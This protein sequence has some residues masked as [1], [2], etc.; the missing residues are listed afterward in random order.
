M[1]MGW[2]SPTVIDTAHVDARIV[3]TYLRLPGAGS[4]SSDAGSLI[5]TAES[6][7]PP[8]GALW[9]AIIM[10]GI[11]VRLQGLASERFLLKL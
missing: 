4:A 11:D 1:S 7:I 10:Q 6:S 8:S 9:Y 5:A 3:Q 2:R